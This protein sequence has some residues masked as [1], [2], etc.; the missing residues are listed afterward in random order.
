MR[1]SLLIPIA[2][3]FAL[4]IIMRQ[5][6]TGVWMEACYLMIQ[7]SYSATTGL[8]CSPTQVGTSRY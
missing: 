2:A 4:Q 8:R 3:L 7:S 5:A 6:R 1:G